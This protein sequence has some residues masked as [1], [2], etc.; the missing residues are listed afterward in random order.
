MKKS[1][2]RSLKKATRLL[3][4]SQR[5]NTEQL[6]NFGQCEARTERVHQVA[7][8]GAGQLGEENSDNE[9]PVASQHETPTAR[10]RRR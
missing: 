6:A 4:R 8:D 1:D 9:R 7:D 2:E 10:R 5:E 3:N